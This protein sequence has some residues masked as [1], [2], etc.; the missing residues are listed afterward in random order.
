MTRSDIRHGVRRLFHLAL[1][2]PDVA[3]ADASAELDSLVDERVDFLVARGMSPAAARAEAVR[4]LGSPIEDARARL[5]QSAEHRERHMRIAERWNELLQDIRFSVRTLRRS[6][7]FAVT[8]ILV[9]ALGIGANT[10]AF[11]VADF[12]LLR[13]LPFAH[14]ERL[15]KIWESPPGGYRLE[16]SP[17]NYHDWKAMATS[18]DA[19]AA[20]HPTAFNLTG[21]GEPERLSGIAVTADLLPLLG[22]KP[23]LGRAFRNGE[24]GTVILGYTLWQ[25]SFAGDSAVVGRAAILDGAP[26][27]VIGVMPAEFR[28]P[29]R[30][31]ALYTPMSVQDLTSDQRGDNWFEVVARLRPGATLETARAEMSLIAKQ[32]EKAFPEENEKIGASVL[33]LRTEF[34]GQTRLL[35]VALCGAALCVL[36]LA[37]AN[38]A[39][40]LIARSLA[41]R[42]ELDVR[43]ALGAGR[44]RLVRQ[45]ITESLVIAVIGGALGVVI[46]VVSVPL[47]SSLVPAALPTAAVPTIDLRIL[48]FAGIVT[49]LT[50][51]GIGVFPAVRA[52]AQTT[53][54]ALR[55]GARSGGGQRARLRSALVIAEVT[56][57]VV[58]LVTGGLLMRALNRLH[59]IDPG[60]RAENVVTM[61]TALPIPPYDTTARRVQYYTQVLASVRALRGV[62]NAAFVSGLPMLM[63]GGIWP[64]SLSAQPRTRGSGNNAALR[65]VTTGFFA[66]MK[67]PVRRG[68]DVQETDA[69]GAPYVAVV[70]ESFVKR[71]FPSE[72]PIGR[73]FQFAQSE[74]T[75]VGVV[76]DVRTRGVEQAAEPQVYLPSAQVPD[77]GIIGYIPKD[78]AIRTVSSIAASSIVPAV[79]R[80]VHDVDPLQPISNVHTMTEIVADRTASRVVQVR[81]IGAFAALAFLLAAVGIH[82]LLA[83]TVSQ[84]KHEFSVRMALGAQPI[85][86]VNL[87]MRQG[88]LLA[89]CGVLPGLLLAYAAARA[90]SAL[91]AG[92]SPGDTETF[93][94]AGGLC[95]VMTLAG[96]LMPVWRAVHVEPASAFRS[97]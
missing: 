64:V 22:V 21:Q 10:A 25:R 30:E 69:A 75:I 47:L 88:V 95:L 80:I 49:V 41:R 51:L 66:T 52:T 73:R 86:I 48:L 58:L 67:I 17:P 4:R 43:I 40:L 84:R 82:G 11:S 78:L 89:V 70:S 26:F 97:E 27:V 3:H 8:A 96:S 36:L 50:G 28:F 55:E 19:M 59:E 16:P 54:G 46:A 13:P 35:L 65:Y 92:V 39:G 34:N 18:Y 32:L 76:G 74:R 44:A 6:P 12:V 56:V 45:L 63:S 33:E 29:N 77:A 2:R 57:S 20:Y 31:I 60:F 62:E 68:R 90:M 71:Y 85:A 24:S 42:K 79:R 72:D 53:L 91:L 7:G 5:R 81:V 94:A 15:V 87:V 14:P 9:T 37:C 83:Y 1:R 38:L 93:V 61:R 23:A